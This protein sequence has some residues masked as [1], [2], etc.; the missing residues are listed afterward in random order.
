MVDSKMSF[1]YRMKF[2]EELARSPEVLVEY[3]HQ[4]NRVSVRIVGHY[5]PLPWKDS[6]IIDKQVIL[7][8][9]RRVQVLDDPNLLAVVGYKLVE[10]LSR[11]EAVK[12]TWYQEAAESQRELRR[13]FEIPRTFLGEPIETR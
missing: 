7:E 13:Q 5:P 10:T 11:Q 8:S 12:Q 1:V 9:D 6:S 4:V 3:A 2:I